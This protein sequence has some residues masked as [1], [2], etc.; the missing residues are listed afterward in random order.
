MSTEAV[1]RRYATAVFE[2]ARESGELEAVTRE[3]GEFAR[4]YTENEEFRLTASSPRLDETDRAAIVSEI[5][6]RM[7]ATSITSPGGH[8]RP[9]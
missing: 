2:L 7:K 5:A 8:T 9:S 4:I 1:A 6:Q 3:L